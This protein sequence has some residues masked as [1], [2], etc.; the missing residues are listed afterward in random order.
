MDV[1]RV[2]M[3]G[4]IPLVTLTVVVVVQVL[5][6][7]WQLFSQYIAR[8]WWVGVSTFLRVQERRQQDS[9]RGPGGWNDDT[10]CLSWLFFEVYTMIERMT[11]VEDGYVER[12]EVEVKRG[13]Y[14]RVIVCETNL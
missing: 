11:R 3:G 1:E 9:Q 14:A 2:A 10:L 4:G 7:L 12:A 8:L 5:E 6:L 13:D